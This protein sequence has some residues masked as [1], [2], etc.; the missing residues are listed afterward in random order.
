MVWLQVSNRRSAEYMQ[1]ERLSVVG[2]LIVNTGYCG[3]IALTV[4]MAVGR[5]CLQENES[6]L[7]ALKLR[8]SLA[9][10]LSSVSLY[11]VCRLLVP[12]SGIFYK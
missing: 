8:P 10:S 1:F 7:R 9:D 2:W 11:L 6:G 5:K 4:K 3:L 12:S